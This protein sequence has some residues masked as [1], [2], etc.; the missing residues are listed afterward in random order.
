MDRTDF[1]F[2]VYTIAGVV[3]F[4]AAMFFGVAGPLSKVECRNIATTMGVEYQWGYTTSC[5]IRRN[6]NQWMP[7]KLYR[8]V[9]R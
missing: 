4:V 8:E 9:I 5:M 3:A 7:L 2:I 1:K 6:G